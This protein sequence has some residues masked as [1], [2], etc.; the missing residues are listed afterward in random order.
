MVR[1]LIALLLALPGAAASADEAAWAA[2]ARGG[3]VVLVRHAATTP[4]AGDPPGFRLEDCATQRNLSQA[5]RREARRLGEAFRSRGV[6]VARVLS[7]PWCRCLESAELAFGV[8]PATHP[9][10]GNLYGRAGNRERQVAALRAL[11]AG[12]PEGGNLVLFTHGS[13]TVAL[14]GEYPAMGEAI[15]VTPAGGG[16]FRVAGR[17]AP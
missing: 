11:I 7:S 17:I 6:R 9:A 8:R 14:T 10:L 3:Q 2:L 1:L 15:V 12:P 16:A 13:T 4:G 5:G